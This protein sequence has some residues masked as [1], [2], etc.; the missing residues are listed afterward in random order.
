MGPGVARKTRVTDGRDDVARNPANGFRDGQIPFRVRIGVTGHRTLT[1]PELGPVVAAQIERLAGLTPGTA[2]TPI[3]LGVVSQLAEGADRRLVEQV[4]AAAK[5]RG[6]EASIEAILPMPQH[7]YV[8][9]QNFSAASA[10]EFESLLDRASVVTEPPC[11]DV[12]TSESRLAAYQLAGRK[13]VARS[14]VLVALWDGKEGNRG[15]TGDTLLY[16]AGRGKPCVWISTA[17]AA[18]KGDNLAEGSSAWFYHEVRSRMPHAHAP[19]PNGH[20]A[21]VLTPLRHTFAGLD[22]FNQERPPKDF[23][24]MLDAE[25]AARDG[26]PEWVAAPLLRAHTLACQYQGRFKRGA[27]LV[28]AFALVAAVMLAITVSVPRAAPAWAFAE[29]I[30][31]IVALVGVPLVHRRGYQ[32]RWLSYRV[33]AERLRSARYVAATAV[34]FVQEARLDAVY[35]PARPEDWV[36][37]AFEEVWAARPKETRPEDLAPDSSFDR[38]RRYLADKWVGGQLRYH[39]ERG[40]YHERLDRYFTFATILLFLG[41]AGAAVLHGAGV[42]ENLAKFLSVTL[43]ALAASVAGINYLGRHRALQQRYARM[44][45]DLSVARLEILDAS[46]ATIGGACAVAARVIAQESGSWLGEMWFLEI[47]HP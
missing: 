12:G 14:D 38:L 34:D 13:L 21:D 43:P 41:G 3:R 27:Y 24:P 45:A 33:L 42:S 44:R 47:E 39:A 18:V 2:E 5:R 30:C 25:I 35:V 7:Q 8:Q 10:A 6:H 26:K 19:E 40:R 28:L 36:I 23:L 31:L 15:G 17:D 37:R 16:A 46:P 32:Q 20:P 9:Y 4:C 1:D 29:A 11:A 22:A